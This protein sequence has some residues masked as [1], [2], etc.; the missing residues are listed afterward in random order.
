MLL[1][2]TR[3]KA[4]LENNAIDYANEDVDRESNDDAPSSF[5]GSAMP[6]AL[7]CGVSGFG[8]VLTGTGYLAHD[9]SLIVA[10]NSFISLASRAIGF[11]GGV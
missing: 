7:L 9:Q 1:G 11:I 2:R 5:D 4:K 10:T 6:F 3:T 8:L